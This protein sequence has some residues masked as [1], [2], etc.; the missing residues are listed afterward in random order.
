MN[1]LTDQQI[2]A[3][4]HDGYLVVPGLYSPDEVAQIQ[5]WTEEIAAWPETPGRHMM[6]FEHEPVTNQRL[7]NRME[8]FSPYHQGFADLFAGEKMLGSVSQLLNEPAVLFKGKVNFKLAGAGGFEPHQ[9]VQAGWEIYGS[10]HI[11]AMVSIDACTIEN[12]CLEMV[13]GAQGKG[14]IGNSWEPLSDE[15][16]KGMDFQPVLTKPGDAVFFDSFAP[17]RSGPNESNDPRRVLYVTYNRLSEG[18]HRQA[19][20]EAKRKSYPQDCEREAGKE[21]VFRV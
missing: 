12:G 1:Y 4:K 6:Y 18:D 19:Y 20:Y 16:M 21:Y 5:S 7:L 2:A 10:L 17:H 8:N 13:A 9:D 14:F 11:T 3:F 15:H